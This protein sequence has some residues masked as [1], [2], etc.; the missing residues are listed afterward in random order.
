MVSNFSSLE[1]VFIQYSLVF[2]SNL[3]RKRCNVAISINQFW[4]LISDSD[5]WW[6][7]LLKVTSH[8]RI[9][10]GQRYQMPCLER[11]VEGLEWEQGRGPKG[12]MSSRTQG[13]FSKL[14]YNSFRLQDKW[15]ICQEA[16]E[17]SLPKERKHWKIITEYWYFDIRWKF[18]LNN[19]VFVV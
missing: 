15:W 9:A 5:F 16:I 13:R 12:P 1:I 11:S 14:S 10:H 8:P 7:Y 6:F 19:L 3:D 4:F 18:L 2:N 17:I